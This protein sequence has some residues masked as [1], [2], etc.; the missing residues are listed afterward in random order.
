MRPL[1][2][3]MFIGL[4]G[5]GAPA[6]AADNDPPITCDLVMGMVGLMPIDNIV[7]AI[8]GQ[9][10][11][12]PRLLQCLSEREAPAALIDAVNRRLGRTQGSGQSVLEVDPSDPRW[13][14]TAGRGIAD[15]A[16][17]VY[18]GQVP[19]AVIYAAVEGVSWV[20]TW[21]Y[22]ELGDR[23]GASLLSRLPEFSEAAESPS[24][25]GEDAEDLLY[26][27]SR[28]AA[29]QLLRRLGFRRTMVVTETPFA[30]TKAVDVA[31]VIRDL[32]TGEV[33]EG[34]T[35]LVPPDAAKD[36]DVD[37]STALSPSEA[38]PGESV[39]FTVVMD[40]RDGGGPA[41]G[42]RVE[43]FAQGSS[44]GVM[45]EDDPG[46]YDITVPIPEGMDADLP[47]T[48]TYVRDDGGLVTKGFEVPVVVPE[49]LFLP[50][51]TLDEKI[52]EAFD[53]TKPHVL[54]GIGLGGYGGTGGPSGVYLSAADSE[55][56]NLASQ[57]PAFA[58]TV[59]IDRTVWG[60]AWGA[61][62]PLEATVTWQYLRVSLEGGLRTFFTPPS[63]VDNNLSRDSAGPGRPQVRYQL[64]G[65]EMIM[66]PTTSLD[67]GGKVMGG[68]WLGRVGVYGG[69]WAAWVGEWA[70]AGIFNPQ[71]DDERQARIRLAGSGY[72]LGPAIAIDVP[73]SARAGITLDMTTHV[74]ASRRGAVA[75]F[76]SGNLKLWVRGL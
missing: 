45:R 21:W 54:V 6:H 20:E 17:L 11:L 40:K 3:A 34:R 9:R 22:R 59:Y 25:L 32:D 16:A 69:V 2:L 62:I 64:E 53:R 70:A 58:N 27:D 49:A 19:V 29:E 43:V 15:A 37:V 5:W 31:F 75:P 72:A 28:P 39:V 50:P 18:P 13:P 60:S 56:Q 12:A 35:R 46:R 51:P 23:V 24:V 4:V 65:T 47:V 73:F 44:L 42:R 52:R 61:R 10:P 74:A 36:D 1:I 30:G 41:S 76:S 67:L 26:E 33:R 68:A 55:G 57:G 8:E 38:R 71:S 63:R 14:E 66:W 7:A 48:W